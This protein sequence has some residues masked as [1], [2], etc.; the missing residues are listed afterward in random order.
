MRVDPFTARACLHAAVAE[1]QT[2]TQKGCS[3]DGVLE[4]FRTPVSKALPS[5]VRARRTACLCDVHRSRTSH[6]T[7]ML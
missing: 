3:L 4:S 2:V 5:W 6:A 7:A 1:V